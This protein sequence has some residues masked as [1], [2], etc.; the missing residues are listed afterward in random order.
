[1]P[2][3]SRSLSSIT[4][5]SGYCC[6]WVQLGNQ[7]CLEGW[8]NKRS[9]WIVGDWLSCLRSLYRSVAYPCIMSCKSPTSILVEAMLEI[10]LPQASEIGVLGSYIGSV[11][12]PWL[13][14]SYFW[15]GRAIAQTLLI[16][17]D[18][19]IAHKR[20]LRSAYFLGSRSPSSTCF[21]YGNMIPYLS[22]SL[23]PCNLYSPCYYRSNTYIAQMRHMKYAGF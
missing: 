11:T 4:E 12:F 3:V 6:T 22:V 18:P 21:M 15:N 9:S 1:M 23:A 17:H 8:G 13:W 14:D 10:S 7:W 19:C 16:E 2:P 20:A 5:T